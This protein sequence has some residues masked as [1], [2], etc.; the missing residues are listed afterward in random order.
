MGFDERRTHRI[1]GWTIGVVLVAGLLSFLAKGADGPKDPYLKST[2][3]AAAPS[4]ATTQVTAVVARTAVPG[5]GEVGIRIASG[6]KLCALLAQTQAQRARGLM[7]RTDLA[8]HAGMVF[9]FPSTATDTF[10]MRNT[11]MP[12]SIA[13]FDA[14]GRFVSA[15]DM[16]PCADRPDCPQYAATN[17]YRYALEVPEGG[18]SSLGVGPGTVL[19]VGGSC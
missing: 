7:G 13:W 12:L 15:A 11:P 9:V 10:Y 19:T 8:G 17:P 6:P 3:A 14:T 16:V 18:L 2:A 1:L 4:T 5:F